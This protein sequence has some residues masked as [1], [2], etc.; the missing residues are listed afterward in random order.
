M[1]R[2][3]PRL[4][5]AAALS[6]GLAFSIVGS[7]SADHHGAPPADIPIPAAEA[8]IQGLP[9]ALQPSFKSTLEVDKATRDAKHSGDPAKMMEAGKRMGQSIK[10]TMEQTL[11]F[12]D[13]ASASDADK[14]AAVLHFFASGGN[15]D[16][17]APPGTRSSA[18][19]STTC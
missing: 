13:Q 10:G 2:R 19:T 17:S 18:R 4:L 12:L 9:S 5:S 1:N 16:G 15:P 7:A 3:I 8:V 14:V 11:Q 6:C